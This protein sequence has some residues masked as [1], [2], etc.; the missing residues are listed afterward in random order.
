MNWS[1]YNP[2]SLKT[3]KSFKLNTEKTIRNNKYININYQLVEEKLNF[4][5]LQT[6]KFLLEHQK[7]MEI[8]EKELKLLDKKLS[9]EP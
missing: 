4:V 1:S 5:K 2:K 7:E 9:E 8:Y 6:E 3:K